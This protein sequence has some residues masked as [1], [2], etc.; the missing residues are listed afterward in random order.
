[1]PK[2]EKLKKKSSGVYISKLSMDYE[3]IFIMKKPIPK[4]SKLNIKHV[5]IGGTV[6]IAWEKKILIVCH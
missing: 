6:I 1:M 2:Y 4:I 3:Y 5:F